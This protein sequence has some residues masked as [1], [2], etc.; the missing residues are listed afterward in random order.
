MSNKNPFPV[1]KNSTVA[2][3]HLDVVAFFQEHDIFMGLNL[4]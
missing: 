2:D 3:S 1:T 4:P